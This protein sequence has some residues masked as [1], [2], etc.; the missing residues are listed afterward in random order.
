MFP[1][2]VAGSVRVTASIV[3]AVWQEIPGGFDLV[4]HSTTT[5]ADTGWRDQSHGPELRSF[6][7]QVRP[8]EATGRVLVQAGRTYVAGIVARVSASSTL[9]DS[10]GRPVRP[11]DPAAFRVWGQLNASVR[12][13]WVQRGTTYIA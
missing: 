12:A 8:H 10:Q 4:G 9:T 1:D 11:P 5:I 13:I 6:S 7:R 3:V 2:V